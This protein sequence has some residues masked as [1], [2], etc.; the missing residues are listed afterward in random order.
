MITWGAGNA[1]HLHISSDY[2]QVQFLSP[3]I[4]TPT[5]LGVSQGAPSFQGESS[6]LVSHCWSQNSDAHSPPPHSHLRGVHIE[7]QLLQSRGNF[8]AAIALAR[9][10][11]PGL[12]AETWIT[13]EILYS[14]LFPAHA[15]APHVQRNMAEAVCHE[16]TPFSVLQGVSKSKEEQYSLWSVTG[17]G[18]QLDSP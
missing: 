12:P 17:P 9:E 10:R 13:K 3:G 4:P 1:S 5:C 14:S 11:R 16:H 15:I 8:H 7:R 18:P 2:Q 6:L